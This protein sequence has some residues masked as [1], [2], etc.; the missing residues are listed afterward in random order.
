MGTTI[1]MNLVLVLLEV[2]RAQLF[3]QSCQC[4]FIGV[5]ATSAAMSGGVIDHRTVEYLRQQWISLDEMFE[6][7]YRFTNQANA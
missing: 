2:Q 1:D 5:D 7:E 6:I 3:S 4:A